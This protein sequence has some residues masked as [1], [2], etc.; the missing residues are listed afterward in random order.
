MKVDIVLPSLNEE[1][2]LGQLID[3]IKQNTTSRIV[4]VDGYSK[5]TTVQIAMEKNVQVLFQQ[6]K[7]K[8]GAIVTAIKRLDCDYI[9]VMDSDYSYDPKDIWKLID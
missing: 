6:G 4:L 7:G 3:E 1:E 2:A 9:L 5:D 8:A